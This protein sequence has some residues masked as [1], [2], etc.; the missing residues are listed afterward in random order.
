MTSMLTCCI[1]RD[2]F[3]QAA[4]ARVFAILVVK[5]VSAQLDV[6]VARANIA[7]E[8]QGFKFRSSLFARVT[9]ID[10]AWG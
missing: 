4:H 2:I 10:E 1:N 6:A 8:L 5:V 3:H 9:G 7:E